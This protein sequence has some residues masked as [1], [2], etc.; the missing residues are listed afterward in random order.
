MNP[1]VSILIPAYN[2]GKWIRETIESASNQTWQRKEIIIVDDGSTDN[3]AA[4]AKE[5]ESN[6]I[7]VI[8]QR[9]SGAC[10]ARN[11]ALALAN[12]EF[13]QWLDAD[14]LLAPDKI[15]K[16]IEVLRGYEGHSNVL[17]TSAYG[18]FYYRHKKAKFV[19]N[20]LWQ[21]LNPVDW[22]LKKFNDG[23]WSF[24]AAWLVSRKLSDLAGPWNEILSYDDDGEYFCRVVSVSN[25]VIFVKDSICYYRIGNLGS[26]S[27]T[28]S[29]KALISLYQ[30]TLLCVRHLLNLEDSDR[31]RSA[32]ISLLKRRVWYFYPYHMKI[33]HEFSDIAI[34]LGFNDLNPKCNLR[35]K[36]LKNIIGWDMALNLKNV[37]WKIET[38]IRKNIDKLFFNLF[39]H[40]NTK[41]DKKNK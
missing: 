17:I 29:E 2:A 4:I 16:Q 8:G 28:F 20:S 12:G 38:I 36:I 21:D 19:E 6:T 33:V 3:T 22:F 13:I 11:K 15:T 32:I 34:N 31:T 40:A 37:K 24:P 41:I 18:I 26:L 25:K 9:N 1:L 35:F 30:S 7:R 23:V 14:D 10:A 5:Y 27:Q 39:D